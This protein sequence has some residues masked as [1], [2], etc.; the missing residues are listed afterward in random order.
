MKCGFPHIYGHLQED[1][2]LETFDK[3][4]GLRKPPPA[5]VPTKT[6]F[7]QSQNRIPLEVTLAHARYHHM[8]TNNCRSQVFLRIL[9]VF[10]LLFL[11]LPVAIIT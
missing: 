10:D 5:L 6:K 9:D 1:Y 4:C 7:S 3:K 8:M 11:N 2:V